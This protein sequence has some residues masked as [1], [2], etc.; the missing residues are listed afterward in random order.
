M[1]DHSSFNDQDFQEH[2]TNRYGY[3]RKPYSHY[4]PA[5][6]HGWEMANSPNY[7][8][9]QWSEAEHEARS[10]WERLNP[11]TLW[12]DIV[13]AVEEGWRKARA[14]VGKPD[15]L[16]KYNVGHPRR[17]TSIDDTGSAGSR[18]AGVTDPD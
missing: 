4:Q 12:D 5:Y 6:H 7:Q 15:L 8:E 16:D 2:Y 17:H 14:A 13:D 3:T 9:Q 18:S 11:A 10:L 1:S